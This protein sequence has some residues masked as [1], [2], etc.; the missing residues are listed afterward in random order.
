[1]PLKQ[2]GLF[3]RRLK[4]SI[5]RRGVAGLL[6][7]VTEKAASVASRLRPS[8][9]A[10]IRRRKEEERAFDERMGVDTGGWIHQAELDAAGPNQLHATAYAGSNPGIFRAAL[11]DLPVD[12][13]RFVFVD[14]GS[15][16]GRAVL[17]ATEFPFKRIVGIE[18]SKELHAIASANLTR[19]P[20]GVAK[21]GDVELLCM[22]VVDY[23]LP[24]DHIVCYFCNPFDS[25]MMAGV[26]SRIVESFEAAPR[27]IFIV[28]HNPFEARVI[29]RTGSF[30]P[31]IAGDSVR[32]WKAVARGDAGG[33]TGARRAPLPHFPC[34]PK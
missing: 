10:G 21:C 24:A 15:G 28:Y 7:V 25:A 33:K 9:K 4:R 16:K 1:M 14:F 19:L 13:R 22:D 6:T 11:R 34:D 20:R 23:C 27:D 17:L 18:F 2:C 29:D 3:A 31:L 8:V 32:V 30:R 5:R 12:Y 26:V